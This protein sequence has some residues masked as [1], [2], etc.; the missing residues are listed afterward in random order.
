MQLVQLA[1]VNRSRLFTRRQVV[2]HA[3]A[4]PARR[5]SDQREREDGAEPM[6]ANDPTADRRSAAD[7]ADG[8]TDPTERD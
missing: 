7:A 5:I 8:N 3:E 1:L 2:G 6:L 4:S